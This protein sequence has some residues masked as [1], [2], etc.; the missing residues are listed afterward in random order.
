MRQRSQLCRTA[1]AQDPERA[2][3]DG[4]AEEPAR[5]EPSPR[6]MLGTRHSMTLPGSFPGAAAGGS[7]GAPAPPPQVE[8]PRSK[9][10]GSLFRLVTLRGTPSRMVGV[11]ACV[12]AHMRRSVSPGLDHVWDRGVSPPSQ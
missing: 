11:R 1:S 3:A 2:P 6:S 7:E 4:G 9:I 5:A 10:S 8:A 12:C